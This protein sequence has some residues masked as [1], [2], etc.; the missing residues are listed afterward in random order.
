MFSPVKKPSLYH[1][2][3]CIFL[4][5][6]FSNNHF[7]LLSGMLHSG[8]GE[9]KLSN[10]LSTLSIPPCSKTTLKK[11][12]REIGEALEDI[13]RSSCADAAV[14]EKDLTK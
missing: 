2:N 4:I 3:S 10:L 7:V 14:R 1:K 8:I 9:R 5:N 6:L 12:E 11:R 13:A